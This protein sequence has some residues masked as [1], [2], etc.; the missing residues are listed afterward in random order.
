[1]HYIL[2]YY[3]SWTIRFIRT[4]GSIYHF[5]YSMVENTSSA[6]SSIVIGYKNTI[7]GEVVLC[8]Q[9]E[10]QRIREMVSF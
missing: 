4:Y 3:N 10:Y 1:M 9:S 7:S 2:N 6:G 5:S 8:S